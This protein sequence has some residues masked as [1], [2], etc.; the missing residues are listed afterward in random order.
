MNQERDL[1]RRMEVRE[2]VE[3]KSMKVMCMRREK[4]REKMIS[5]ISVNE[6]LIKIICHRI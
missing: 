3:D 4:V 6:L 1:E 2:S 5:L